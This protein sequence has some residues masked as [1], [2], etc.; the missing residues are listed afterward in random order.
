MDNRELPEDKKGKTQAV[1][2]ALLSAIYAVS[3]LD[4]VPD[5][6]VIGWIDDWFVLAAAALNL[7]EHFTGREHKSLRNI[8]K[9]A[10]RI[11]IIVG[12]I[13]ILL[14]LIFTALVISLISSLF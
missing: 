6:P 8:L 13:V 10:K 1:V 12:I 2:L 4:I 7:M 5:I 11:I 14:L 9:I 3:P